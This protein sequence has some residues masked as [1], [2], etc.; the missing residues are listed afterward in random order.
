MLLQLSTE[1]KL[2][3]TF[4]DVVIF[5]RYC[6]DTKLFKMLQLA[7]SPSCLS[8]DI[9]Y[10]CLYFNYFTE[11]SAELLNIFQSDII[12]YFLKDK[13]QLIWWPGDLTREAF[14]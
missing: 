7:C 11:V 14:H 2:K 9:F 8:G 5:H 12:A 6:W 3:H 1:G 4:L 13:V 10:V